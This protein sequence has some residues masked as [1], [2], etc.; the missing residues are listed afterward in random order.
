MV[1]LGHLATV[2]EGDP[3]ALFTIA[4][5][6][7]C[8]EGT[9]PFPG[10]L[11]FNIDSHLIVL[12]AKQGGIKYHFFETLVWVDMGLNPGLPNHLRTLYILDL[13]GRV[14]ANGPED[15]G[16]IPGCVIPKTRNGTLYLLP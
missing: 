14:F 6:L 13:V 11:H 5:T 2:V 4:T 16:S 3:K 9:T 12:S 8:R 10:L 7:R 1:R 15:L